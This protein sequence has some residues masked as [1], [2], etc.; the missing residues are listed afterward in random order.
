M[1]TC[2]RHKGLAQLICSSGK[3]CVLGSQAA[4]I[5]VHMYVSGAALGVTSSRSIDVMYPS[6][7]GQHCMKCS[8]Q[9]IMLR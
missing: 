8:Q 4:V 2:M 1:C 5:H 6:A 7:L 3:A 9:T